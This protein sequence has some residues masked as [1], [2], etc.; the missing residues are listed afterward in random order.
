MP[1]VVFPVAA[2][3]SNTINLLLSLLPMAL[4][5]LVLGHPFYP[6]WLTCQCPCWR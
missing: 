2:V 3:V 4:V 1:K 5:V 6:T